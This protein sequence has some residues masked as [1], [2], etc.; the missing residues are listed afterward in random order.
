MKAAVDL[1]AR[2]P[3]AKAQGELAAVVLDPKYGPEVR[4]AAAKELIRHIQKN[5]VVLSLN[6]VRLLQE[7][8]AAEMD[9]SLKATLAELQGSLR[10]DARTSG[11]RLLKQP[12]PETKAKDK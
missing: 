12:L 4:S 5:S 3:G 7:L 2:Q 9:K 6:Q 1:A 11:E 8:Y 10:P